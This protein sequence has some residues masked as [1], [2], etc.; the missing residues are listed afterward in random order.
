MATTHAISRR[1][2]VTYGKAS[3]LGQ[4]RVRK[5][6]KVSELHPTAVVVTDQRRASTS[7][8][9]VISPSKSREL[10]SIINP[11][12]INL[13]S[14]KH[15]KFSHRQASLIYCP[16][17]PSS[18][19]WCLGTARAPLSQSQNFRAFHKKRTPEPPVL[20][21]RTARKP[22]VQRS[23][24]RLSKTD[25]ADKRSQR[26]VSQSVKE[27]GNAPSTLAHTT[28][29]PRPSKSPATTDLTRQEELWSL[30][31]PKAV[32]MSGSDHPS[33]DQRDQHI[34]FRDP[35]TIEA[36]NSPRRS[37]RLS[38]VSNR[39]RRLV[40]KLQSDRHK[41]QRCSY[42]SYESIALSNSDN[43]E[44]LAFKVA[45][46][47]SEMGSS[48]QSSDDS[49]AVSPPRRKKISLSSVQHLPMAR[50]G[51]K[52]TYSCQRSYLANGGPHDGSS[53]DLPFV[54]D[55][56]PHTG[57]KRGKRQRVGAATLDRSIEDPKETEA[58]IP[59]S[60]S[61]R[62]IH[63]LREAGEN[64]RHLNDT[65]TLFDEIDGQDAVPIGLKR[66]K[67]L[68]LLRRLQEP[69][70]GRLLIDQGFATRLLAEAFSREHD[71]IMDALLA[72]AV[73]HLVAA[74]LGG[75]AIPQSH[76][77][78]AAEL[79]AS[80]LGHDRD[81]LS[82]SQ[83]RR[84]NISKK[85]QSDLKQFI[86]SI[87]HS[88]IWRGETPAKVSSHLIALQGLEY[89]VRKRREAGCK[90]EILPSG[91]LQRVVKSLS[92]ALALPLRQSSTNLLLETRLIVSILEPC[93]INGASHGDE[94]W[95]AQTLEPI[96]AILPWLSDIPHKESEGMQALVLRLYLN[97]TN[98]NP[99]LCQ[100]FARLEAIHAIVE[101]V[102]S[103]FRIMSDPEQRLERSSMLD[104]L[105]LAL[106]TLINLVE[107][108]LSIRL[109][110][111]GHQGDEECYL[112]TLLTLFLSRRK[113][114]TKVYSEE[115][116]AFNVAFGYLSVLLSYL[117]IEEE[118]RLKV[119]NRLKGK[120]LQPLLDA[121]EEFLQY[122]RQIDE[123]LGQS[124]GEVDLKAS[125]VSRLE[126]VMGIMKPVR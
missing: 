26:V 63:E 43:E 51:S 3:R 30:L 76:D 73:L 44:V 21:A 62:T 46:P 40:D 109:I 125:F 52:A 70:Y 111:A 97:L 32:W 4:N 89:L 20:G 18:E 8:E 77:L 75:Q 12:S 31:L 54:D 80:R 68:E 37:E 87:S 57:T 10:A 66:E 69:A 96:L 1:K 85:G 122:H 64:N 36:T 29:T 71:A 56:L 14:S 119:M 50:G 23:R 78:R 45:S 2:P 60:S 113:M 124:E 35:Q 5:K 15:S 13:S 67:M 103:R 107:W 58:D 82:V 123:E 61:M 9:E 86:D 84:S 126:G 121:V 100:H 116:T 101:V 117:C 93:T 34:N 95:N 91:I 108:S 47:F 39:H 74:P 114:A 94:Q 41:P 17:S 104:T 28:Q 102:D 112:H 24:V 92:L 22:A 48:S 83:G 7:T 81:L 6:R 42:S 49:N 110:M 118:A 115:E 88:A 65:E 38:A 105:I 79:L 59:Q 99:Q 11:V 25:L 120:N 90:T 33:L 53:F 106:G 19:R 72:A 98:N 55:S 27:T 16:T